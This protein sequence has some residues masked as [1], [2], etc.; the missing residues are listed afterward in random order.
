MYSDRLRAYLT[1]R[2]MASLPFIDLLRARR[3]LRIVRSIRYKLIKYKLVLH[4]TDKSG[5]LYTG[6]V[7]DY[8][9]KAK[10]YR[11]KPGAYEQWRIQ[12]ISEGVAVYLRGW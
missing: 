11:Q 10:E 9:R 5:V 12:K 6:Q 8:H 1:D 3:E 4:R 7:Q 2:Y